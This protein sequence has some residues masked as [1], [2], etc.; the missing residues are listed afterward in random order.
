MKSP[1]CWL[2]HSVVAV[3]F[4]PP[5]ATSAG[6]R[7]SAVVCCLTFELTGALRQAATGRARTIGAV[8]WS[9]QATTAVAR[10]VERGVRQHC[11]LW[12]EDGNRRMPHL[13]LTKRTEA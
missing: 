7:H 1:R 12:P 3:Q 8:A 6:G 11:G 4:T 2:A 9:G 13:L 10:P 5:G